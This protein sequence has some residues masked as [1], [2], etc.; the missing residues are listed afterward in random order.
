MQS[1]DA[2]TVSGE[3]LTIYTGTV[4][5]STGQDNADPANAR[6]EDLD[7][8]FECNLESMDLS[9]KA[10]RYKYREDTGIKRI[11]N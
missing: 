4:Q 6:R 8:M 9:T 1:R 10:T 11:V 2:K 3:T 5:Y 7:L